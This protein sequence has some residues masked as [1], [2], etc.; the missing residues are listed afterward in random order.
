MDDFANQKKAYIENIK[1]KLVNFLDKDSY[2][3]LASIRNSNIAQLVAVCIKLDDF[4][5]FMTTIENRTPMY[6]VDYTAVYAHVDVDLIAYI[7]IRIACGGLDLNE[8]Y[9][10]DNVTSVYL[11]QNNTWIVKDN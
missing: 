9:I 2:L 10:T 8:L 4:D 6:T 5:P 11:R 7:L 1:D 3:I